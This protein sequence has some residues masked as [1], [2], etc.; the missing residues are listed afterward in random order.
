MGTSERAPEKTTDSVLPA[1]Q[2]VEACTRFDQ[3]DAGSY[4]I[5]CSQLSANE[6][7]STSS[8]N[9]LPQVEGAKEGEAEGE[10]K[11]IVPSELLDAAVPQRSIT[12]LSACLSAARILL[13]YTCPWA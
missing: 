6:S 11:V 8:K 1:A 10:Q 12:C 4:A 7:A 3:H 13:L 2:N 5:K 9:I